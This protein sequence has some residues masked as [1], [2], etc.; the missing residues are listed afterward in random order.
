MSSSTTFS[1]LYV[2]FHNF[3][4]TLHSVNH[5]PYEIEKIGRK[6]YTETPVRNVFFSVHFGQ[7][8]TY[9]TSEVLS[10]KTSTETVKITV[11]QNTI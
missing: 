6:C 10:F 4:R 5:S 3:Y 7:R 1:I 9:P 11:F 8:V 2:V